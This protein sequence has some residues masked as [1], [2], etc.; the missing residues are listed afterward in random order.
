MSIATNR[1]TEKKIGDDGEDAVG[2]LLRV[3]IS[4]G[5]DKR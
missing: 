5:K 1:T 2:E 3:R 4:E